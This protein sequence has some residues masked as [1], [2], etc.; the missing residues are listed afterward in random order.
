MSGIGRLRHRVTVSQEQKLDDGMG[1]YS[2]EWTNLATT[3]ANVKAMRISEKQLAGQLDSVVTHR[4]TMRCRSDFAI[5]AGM[6]LLWENV[7]LNILGV[8]NPDGRNKYW[9]LEC[10]EGGTV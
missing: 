5:H 9:Q 4:V 2:H 1:G 8:I 6:T 3:W 7:R 10:R